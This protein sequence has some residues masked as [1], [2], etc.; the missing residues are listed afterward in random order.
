MSVDLKSLREELVAEVKAL[1]SDLTALEARLTDPPSRDYKAALDRFLL[2]IRKHTLRELQVLEPVLHAVDAW[3]EVRA[4]KM[5]E[6][7]A[8]LFHHGESFTRLEHTAANW[9]SEAQRLLAHLR[10]EL[11][12]D[13]C[14]RLSPEVLHD[15]LIVVDFGG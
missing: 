9:P 8:A 13:E 6:S 3:G 10:D 14:M 4:E 5:D 11:D 1:R 7:R 12:E 15:E 2:A